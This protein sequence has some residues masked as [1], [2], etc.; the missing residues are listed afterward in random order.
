MSFSVGKSEK[1]RN[2]AFS[3]AAS[4]NSGH[5]SSI[6]SGPSH[7]SVSSFFPETVLFFPAYFL[8]FSKNLFPVRFFRKNFNFP[9]IFPFS[10]FPAVFSPCG[11]FSRF[12]CPVFSF[13][14]KFIFSFVC[15]L[16]LNN[17]FSENVKIQRIKRQTVNFSD[18]RNP[19]DFPLSKG[20]FLFFFLLYFRPLFQYSPAVR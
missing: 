18:C 5:S 12:F 6:R 7:P 11:K 1:I 14:R 3:A 13:F 17:F 20:F 4:E 10:F 15:S 19:K 9:E 16:F 2:P 8:S